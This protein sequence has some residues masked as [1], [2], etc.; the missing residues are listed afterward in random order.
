MTTTRP[1]R[2]AMPAGAAAAELVRCAGT[3]FDAA[4]VDAL[5]AVVGVPADADERPLAA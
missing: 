2:K 5:L 1:Y 3:Q 4:V